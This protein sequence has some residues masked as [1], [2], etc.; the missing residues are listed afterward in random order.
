MLLVRVGAGWALSRLLGEA[1][2]HP[3]KCLVYVD[4][5]NKNNSRQLST[6]LRAPKVFYSFVVVPP[7]PVLSIKTH[8]FSTTYFLNCSADFSYNHARYRNTA[9]VPNNI[10]KS[11][12]TTAVAAA[13]LVS[14]AFAA[15]KKR[16]SGNLAPVRSGSCRVRFN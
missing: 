2:G 1:T 15:V 9:I 3:W 7:I 11:T 10:M 4:G 12:F 14:G 5:W 8:F 6:E 13:S 16:Q